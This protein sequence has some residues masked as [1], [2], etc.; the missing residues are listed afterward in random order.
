MHNKVKHFSLHKVHRPEKIKDLKIKTVIFLLFSFITCFVT[1]S[2]TTYHSKNFTYFTFE[3]ALLNKNERYF[4]FYNYLNEEILRGQLGFGIPFPKKFFEC[5]NES[6]ITEIYSGLCLE[7][8][9]VAKLALYHK[10]E[11]TANCYYIK[12]IALSEKILP[13]DCYEL[14]RNN[15]IW[16]GASKTKNLFLHLN[17]DNFTF[18][19][20]ISG[21]TKLSIFGN[22][23]KRYFI[24]SLGVAISIEN[25]VPLHISV[26]K[27]S[28]LICFRAMNDDFAFVNRATKMPQLSYKVCT[29][30]DDIKGLHRIMTQQ[31]LWKNLKEPNI[32]VLHSVIEEPIWKIPTKQ[33]ASILNETIIY[34]YS[35]NIIQMGYM[36]LGHILVN[37]FWQQNIGDLTVHQS[38]FQNLKNVIDILHRRGFKIVFTI[39]PFVST[40]SSNFKYL[41]QN[42]LL[43]FE[44]S[45]KRTVPAL[46]KYKSMLSAAVLDITNNVT[47]SWIFQKLK[48]IKENYHVDYFYLDLGSAYNFPYYYQCRKPLVSP[49]SYFEAFIQNLEQIGFIGISTASFTPKP[50]TF[51]SIPPLNSSWESLQELMIYILLYGILGFPFIIPGSVGGD[52]LLPYNNQKFI[53]SN[54]FEQASLPSQELYIRWLQLIIFLPVVQFAHLPSEYNNRTVTNISKELTAIRQ[55]SV[56]PLLKKYSIDSINEGTPLVRPLWMLDPS[57]LACVN[58]NDEFS[59]GEDL[60]VAPILNQG[61]TSREVYLPQGVWKDGIDGSLRKGSRWIHSYKVPTEKV[62]YFVKMPDNTRF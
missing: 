56:I 28:N 57:D 59:I 7:W 2:Y 4:K 30:S 23:I 45:S 8:E 25:K 33:K 53:N 1:Y 14:S 15:G 32:K 37:E 42:K 41:V 49:D 34:N 48:Q 51:L 22:G 13:T 52:F 58:L 55:K 29:K 50:P 39:Q 27:T 60:I 17:N 54:S 35:E 61:I 9:D 38:R 62:A 43:V 47:V 44:R 36:K 26:N 31:N 16:F 18:Q 24:N 10:I 5:K 3:G 40:E 11:N 46:T 21:D 12:W 20:L 6:K 19:P